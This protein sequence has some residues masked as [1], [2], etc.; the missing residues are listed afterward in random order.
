MKKCSNCK[1]MIDDSAQF[2]PECGCKVESIYCCGTCAKEI[3]A[4]SDFCPYC[5]AP[6]NRNDVETADVYIQESTPTET[7]EVVD[8]EV[9]SSQIE[10]G[11]SYEQN[12]KK[13]NDEVSYGLTSVEGQKH[14]HKKWPLLALC[15]TIISVACILGGWY[16]YGDIQRNRVEK[17]MLAMQI[18]S[19]SRVNDR[20]AHELS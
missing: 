16:L 11:S 19:I 12:T 14:S 2:C 4:D 8:S 9:L 13:G 1:S 20:N 17:D 15:L 5:G 3:D 7:K 18:D 10:Q 6:Q